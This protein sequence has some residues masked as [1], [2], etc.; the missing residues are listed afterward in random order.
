MKKAAQGRQFL[1]QEERNF[2]EVQYRNEHEEADEES[3]GDILNNRL[4]F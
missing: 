3:R 4:S 2:A 1:F